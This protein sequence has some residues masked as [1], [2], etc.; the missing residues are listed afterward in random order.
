LGIEEDL[1]LIAV[2][3]RAGECATID[4]TEGRVMR[5]AGDLPKISLPHAMIVGKRRAIAKTRI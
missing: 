2:V 4:L 5:C 3:A 1:P